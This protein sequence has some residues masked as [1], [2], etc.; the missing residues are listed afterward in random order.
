MKFLQSSN[1]IRTSLDKQL[2]GRF[3]TI[4]LNQNLKEGVQVRK[5][6]IAKTFRYMRG[7]KKD[8]QMIPASKENVEAIKCLYESNEW[9]NDLLV[10]LENK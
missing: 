6:S 9:I 2:V 5:Q 8:P 3:L 1:F 7:L 10:V 4:Y